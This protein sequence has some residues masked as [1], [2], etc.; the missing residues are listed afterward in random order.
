MK[1]NFN[2]NEYYAAHGKVPRGKAL[3]AFEVDTGKAE[4]KVFWAYGTYTEAK[5]KVEQYV[6]MNDCSPYVKVLP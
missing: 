1:L 6:C 4:T 2:I 5:D 3:W